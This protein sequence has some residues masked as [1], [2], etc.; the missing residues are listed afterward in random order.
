MRTSSS[1]QVSK[2]HL[3]TEH[4]WAVE[5]TAQAYGTGCR[6]NTQS[7]HAARPS[8]QR[9][10]CFQS[11]QVSKQHLLSRPRIR[12]SKQHPDALQP[13]P[14]EQR[15]WLTSRW[16]PP[17]VNTVR[18]INGNRNLPP[19]V[20]PDEGGASRPFTEGGQSLAFNTRSS[21]APCSG[22]P[23]GQSLRCRI[24]G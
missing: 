3:S 8:K 23:A 21:V 13:G 24:R 2:Q 14:S 7:V 19:S 17:W 15:P 6:N 5:T 1:S 11:S 16:V 9:P 12:V 22:L 20:A 18:S 10:V 4:A